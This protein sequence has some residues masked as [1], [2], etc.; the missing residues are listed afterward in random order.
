MENQILDHINKR[1]KDREAEVIR[2]LS[3]GGCK[4]FDH[5][6][7]LCGFIRGLQTAQ[8]EIG[9]LLRKIKVNDD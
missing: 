5:Y 1:M 4:S 6:K 7:E 9:D 2:V 8:F 3:D